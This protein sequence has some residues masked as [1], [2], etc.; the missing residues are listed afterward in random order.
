MAFGGAGHLGQV[1]VHHRVVELLD[2]GVP[3]RADRVAGRDEVEEPVAVW[4][5]RCPA[6]HGD[7]DV[8]R[9]HV[10]RHAREVAVVGA[11]RV[12]V[13]LQLD[14]DLGQRGLHGL[15]RGDFLGP[16]AAVG[17]PGGE[18]VRVTAGLERRLGR[19]DVAAGLGGGLVQVEVLLADDV[20]RGHRAGDR[21]AGHRAAV[22]GLQVRLVRRV[23]DRLT[24]VQVVQ[25]RDLGV[26]V[27]EPQEPADRVVGGGLERRRGQDLGPRRR[28]HAG[29]GRV[30]VQVTREQPVVEVVRVHVPV[31][32][33]LAGQL[34]WR[35]GRWTPSRT[36]S[37]PCVSVLFSW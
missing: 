10:V 25:R 1:V 29:A 11:R 13:Q 32:D 17:D 21:A 23:L 7:A 27:G 5:V 24:A 12:A 3:G 8:V 2:V 6:A 18:P 33:D 9:V 22:G 26:E 28:L 30:H 37:A 36:C 35:S 34:A 31:D 14:P 15:R 20:R 19:R 16:V 4:P